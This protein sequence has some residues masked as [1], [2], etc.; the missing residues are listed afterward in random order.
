MS[1]PAISLVEALATARPLLGTLIS[2]RSPEVAEALALCGF[3]WLFLD[4]EHATLDMAAAQQIIQATSHHAYTVL[5]IPDNTPEHFKKAL[6]T[7]CDGVIVPM[8]N[9]RLAAEIAVRSAKYPPIGARSVGLGRAHGYG[10]HFADYVAN[11]N[12]TIALILQIEHINGVREI[13]DILSVPGFDAIFI[14]PFD[15]SA[16]MGLIGQT[17]HPEVLAAIARVRAACL[18]AG[19]PFGAFCPTVAAAREQIAAHG[20]LIVIGTDLSAMTT[21]ARANLSALTTPDAS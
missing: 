4:L 21:Q 13:D 6:D 16:S 7:G 20:Q 19:K 14:G 18:A 2:V 1:R 15:L 11:A 8:V 5:R 12:R 17:T 10:L 3:D 9:S